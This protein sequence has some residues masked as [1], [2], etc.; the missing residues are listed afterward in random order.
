MARATPARHQRPSATHGTAPRRHPARGIRGA[1]VPSGRRPH[2]FRHLSGSEEWS[3]AQGILGRPSEADGHPDIGGD[4]L[5]DSFGDGEDWREQVPLANRHLM[6]ARHG[7][8]RASDPLRSTRTSIPS[9]HVRRR[10]LLRHVGQLS[11]EGPRR[12]RVHARRRMRHDVVRHHLP[13][14]RRVRRPAPQ[15][16]GLH[17]RR[18]VRGRRLRDA[19]VL[20]GRA[21]HARR[22]HAPTP[23][24]ALLHNVIYGA[25]SLLHAL[26][27]MGRSACRGSFQHP[28]NLCRDVVVV[29]QT[30]EHGDTHRHV[31]WTALPVD[32][33]DGSR[34]ADS[35]SA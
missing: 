20:R 30:A 23:A 12:W 10:P 2:T 18:P 14:F 9:S 28:P 16:R 19:S 26:S 24:V 17:V 27:S 33:R 21:H 1:H 31:L 11:V 15:R 13:D 22:L 3:R 29:V 8:D 34:T 4:R 32:S 7:F 6:I 5:R 35:R 25:L